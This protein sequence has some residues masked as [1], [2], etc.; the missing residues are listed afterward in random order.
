MDLLPVYL[1]VLVLMVIMQEQR[2][3]DE[4]QITGG[5]D[6]EYFEK[7]GALRDDSVKQKKYQFL[8]VQNESVCFSEMS[9]AHK[10]TWAPAA[11]RGSSNAA[12]SSAGY[13]TGGEEECCFF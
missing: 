2:N 7:L 10:P 5:V 1:N 11:A 6:K 3:S 12:I 8:S 13:L 9:T 4:V